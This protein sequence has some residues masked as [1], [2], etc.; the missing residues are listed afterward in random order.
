MDPRRGAVKR[1]AFQAAG[2]AEFWIIDLDS[3]V[4][5][6]WRPADDRPEVLID[7]LQWTPAGAAVGLDIDLR[8][9]FAG[10]LD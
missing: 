5:E 1:P 4:V 10:L 3:R 9:L 2:V 8:S 6:R 7:R